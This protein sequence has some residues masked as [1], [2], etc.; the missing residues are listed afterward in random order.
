MRA[1]CRRTVLCTL[2]FVEE[3]NIV[4]ELYIGVEL[5]SV[6]ESYI[7]LELYIVIELYFIVVHRLHNCSFVVC[8]VDPEDS[9]EPPALHNEGVGRSLECLKPLLVRYNTTTAM[10]TKTPAQMMEPFLNHM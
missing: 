3:S 2:Y 1:I 6:E 10:I 5:C 9:E 4:V 7:V 8:T